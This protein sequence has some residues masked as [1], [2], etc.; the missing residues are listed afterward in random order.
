MRH[1]EMVS[2]TALVQQ[3]S[4]YRSVSRKKVKVSRSFS[5][6]GSAADSR[7]MTTTSM[8]GKYAGGDI[9]SMAEIVAQEKGDFYQHFR[10]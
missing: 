6:P 5:R 9:V 8:I 3:S 4:P 2:V 7:G 1:S 10:K